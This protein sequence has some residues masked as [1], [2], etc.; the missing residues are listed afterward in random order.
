MTAALVDRAVQQAGRL[1]G[2]AEFRGARDPG[3]SCAT[4]IRYLDRQLRS[5]VDLINPL[6]V[7]DY[8]AIP[9]G[10]RVGT[11]RRLE[12][13]AVLPFDLEQAS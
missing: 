6:N 3:V 13:P 9:D 10:A 11:V 2:Q 7:H 12:Q 8:V 5:V 1:A 4:I